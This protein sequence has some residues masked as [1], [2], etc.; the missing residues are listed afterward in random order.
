MLNVDAQR[1][2]FSWSGT[3][4]GL[5]QDQTAQLFVKGSALTAKFQVKLFKKGYFELACR[6]VDC[7]K[8]DEDAVKVTL[9]Y[10]QLT[11]ADTAALQQFQEDMEFLKRHIPGAPADRRMPSDRPRA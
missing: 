2:Q 11:P 8:M 5:T 4:N 3:K 9:S 1:L 6:V 10:E 7:S